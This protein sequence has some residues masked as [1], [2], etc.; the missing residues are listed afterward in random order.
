MVS[1][2][3]FQSQAEEIFAIV[4]DEIEELVPDY[5]FTW[6]RPAEEYPEAM[7]NILWITVKSEAL[8]W[9]EKNKPMA[10]FKPMFI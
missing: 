10:W 7:Y 9:I 3:M 6:D 5:N 8:K 1:R 2:G 4:K